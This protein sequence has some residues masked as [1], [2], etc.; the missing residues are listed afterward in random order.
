M[1]G[2][3]ELMLR[4]GV[5]AHRIRT[6]EVA[7][8][9]V[10]LPARLT[11]GRGVED[12][13][14]TIPRLYSLCAHAHAAAAAGALEA[15]SGSAPGPEQRQQRAFDVRRE[16]IVELLSR[17]LIDWP[18]VLELQPD[19]AAIARVRQAAPDR[20]LAV[21]NEIAHAQ[22]FGTEVAA[23][24]EAGSA[25][26]ERWIDAA[27]T[28][29]ARCLRGLLCDCADLGRSAVETMPETDIDELARML[30]P[31]DGSA[32][33]SRRPKWNG[34]PVETGAIA[35]HVRDPRVGLFS[36]RYG[37]SVA[38]RFLAQLVDLAMALAAHRSS[39]GVQQVAP[40]PGIGIGLAQTARGLLLHQARVH[41][42]RVLDY[43][44]IAP[45][46]WN[47]HPDGALKQG[48]VERPVRDAG[49]AR[50]DTAL[51]VQALDPCVACSIEVVDA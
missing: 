45:T 33:F 23:W 22:V 21:C 32:E 29:P 11:H 51:L 36:E 7:S 25:D 28:L 35:R 40:V 20:Q 48:L 43:R 37:N 49:A 27:A 44:I 15:A 13:A 17:L 6:I 5:A 24:L 50:R 4:V 16:A 8:T 19:V 39:E 46:E 31:L 38:T 2:E 41:A 26:V 18:R 34:I 47:F 12:V 9:R 14:R 1:I 42:G 30:P 3:G 10:P